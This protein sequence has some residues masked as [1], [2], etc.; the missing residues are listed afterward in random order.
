M[1]MALRK[2]SNLR[3][4]GRAVLLFILVIYLLTSSTTAEEKETH[5]LMI[6]TLEVAGQEL[7]LFEA[8]PRGETS[9]KVMIIATQHGDEPAG[10][11]TLIRLIKS[12]FWKEYPEIDFTLVFPA[13]PYGFKVSQRRDIWNRDLNRHWL[14]ADT[15][16]NVA[17]INLMKSYSPDVLIDLHEAKPRPDADY[18][19]SFPNLGVK[20]SSQLRSLTD[21]LS[22]E[23]EEAF[24]ERG[25][26]LKRYY[27]LSRRYR[28]RSERKVSGGFP[29]PR[30]LR[31]YA[32]LRGYFPVL[33]ES[34][35][36][37]PLEERIRHHQIA[38]RVILRYLNKNTNR[39]KRIM[40][41][42]SSSFAGYNEKRFCFL[43]PKESKPLIRYLEIHGVKW[44]HP[45]SSSYL[46]LKGYKVLRYRLGMRYWEPCWRLKVDE[47]SVSRVISR[48]D[49][50][51]PS[52]GRLD[53]AFQGALVRYFLIPEAKCNSFW[54]VSLRWVPKKGTLLPL[55][56][57]PE[58][59]CNELM[60]ESIE[61]LPIN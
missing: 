3:L 6:R 54:E 36:E 4:L 5:Y 57:V 49:Y 12:K 59:D 16:L 55:Y 18:M 7:Y 26:K 10:T 11:Y 45:S 17:L 39:L 47:V 38:L 9:L 1:R 2:V 31:N 14:S 32:F 50:I 56:L 37:N 52:W 34:I 48:G 21:K 53:K 42:I 23:L 35:R 8:H 28:G 30:I 58:E 25:I 60:E 20:D 22:S 40:S 51:V 13:N 24:S 44:F 46:R 41:T 27:A 33:L 43:I 61:K 19:Y 15:P 29:S